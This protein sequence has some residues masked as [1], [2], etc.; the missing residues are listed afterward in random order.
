MAGRVAEYSAQTVL[1]GLYLFSNSSLGQQLT[2]ND[3]C[4]DFINALSCGKIFIEY[5]DHDQ[6]PIGCMTWCFLTDEQADLMTTEGYTPTLEDYTRNAGDQL[7]MFWTI[8]LQENGRSL[9]YKVKKLFNEMYG[10]KKVYW[11]RD[12]DFHTRIHRGH[13]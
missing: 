9:A 13:S 10:R 3:F 4:A 12:T 5:S 6:K 7:W 11:V 8:A 2:I 1:D